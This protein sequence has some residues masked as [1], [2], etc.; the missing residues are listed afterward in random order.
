MKK[1]KIFSLV[2]AIML[3]ASCATAQDN[4]GDNTESSGSPSENV[5][6]QSES[7]GSPT[8]NS[9]DQNENVADRVLKNGTVY[10]VDDKNPNAQAVAI[11][12]GKIIYVGNDE[13]AAE[14]I[15]DNTEVAD[16]G[17]K[18]VLPGFIDTHAHF[19][20]SGVL[21]NAVTLNL[22]DSP[23]QWKQQIREFAEKHP[24]DPG[25]LG[26]GI[27]AYKFGE[28]GP[29]KEE[30]DEIVPDRPALIIDSGGHSA[31]CN[32]KAYE[33]AGITRDTPDPVPGV[34]MYHRKANGEPSGWNKEAMTIY[35]IINKLGLVSSE[36]IENG[37]AEA[38]ALLPELGI[39]AYYD[40][41]MI[42][43]EDQVY[44]ALQALE[45]KGKLPV[46]VVSSYMVQSPEQVPVAIEKIKYF[47]DNYSSELVRPNTI[48]IHN[49]GTLEVETAALHEHYSDTPDNRGGILLAGDKLQNFVADLAKND[50]NVHIHAVGDRTISESLDAVE[51]ARQEAPNTKSTF[52][53]AHAILMRDQDVPRFGQLDVFAQTTPAWITTEPCLNP[54]I[55]A[56]RSQQRYR[57][58][59]IE[60]GGGK[61]TFGS[62]YP[63]GGGYALY[64]FYNIEAGVTRNSLTDD[65]QV[66]PAETE[67]MSLDSMIQGYTI[68]A[69]RQLNM[70]DEIGSIEVGKSADIIVLSDNLFEIETDQIRNVAVVETIMN[71][72]T[73]YTKG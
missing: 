66:F 47:N 60:N 24:D 36:M 25:I 44:P 15:G 69:A 13:G 54:S 59:S 39:T 6:S 53:I 5:N 43:M 14:Y 55:G 9:E 30:L 27:H 51:F 38:F 63:V 33:L 26:I 32:S 18:L 8:E 73:T 20:S 41:G 61:V 34:H 23:E 10:T 1:V 2:A 17:G 42:Q 65:C 21:S 57:I 58:Q 35:P 12:D 11:K 7:S 56:E 64:P 37:A 71:G 50:L 46:K 31:W 28:N 70:E 29:T 45:Q 19:A 3:M 52:T 48:K 72:N 68:N 62:D 4:P 22:K 40:G 49:D 67:K 16:L